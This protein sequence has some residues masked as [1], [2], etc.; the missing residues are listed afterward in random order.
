MLD[1]SGRPPIQNSHV[2]KTSYAA[3][4]YSDSGGSGDHEVFT[5]QGETPLSRV[6]GLGCDGGHDRIDK[7]GERTWMPEEI[8]GEVTGKS[9]GD[10]KGPPG[11]NRGDGYSPFRANQQPR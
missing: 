4:V 11:L 2:G 7:H 1:N 5:G 8:L 9:Y 3:V 6:F 10:L